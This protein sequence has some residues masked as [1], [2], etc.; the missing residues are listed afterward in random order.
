MTADAKEQQ[1]PVRFQSMGPL[2]SSAILAGWFFTWPCCPRKQVSNRSGYISVQVPML[3]ELFTW[4]DGSEQV[5]TLVLDNVRVD[6][7]DISGEDKAESTGN[8]RAVGA[9]G[10]QSTGGDE[11]ALVDMGCVHR[12]LRA[13][14][15]AVDAA[16]IGSLVNILE[17][18]KEQSVKDL[19]PKERLRRW[20]NDAMEALRQ[21]VVANTVRSVTIEQWKQS[22]LRVASDKRGMSAA[23]NVEEFVS[24]VRFS[25][26]T[27]ARRKFSTKPLPAWP[28]SLN[29]R[30][31]QVSAGGAR[32]VVIHSSVVCQLFRF[33]DQARTGKVDIVECVCFFAGKRSA[34]PSSETNA[35][36]FDRCWELL[37]MQQQLLDVKSVSRNLFSVVDPSSSGYI[38]RDQLR[39]ALKKKKVLLSER[40]LKALEAA[41]DNDEQDNHVSTSSFE[42][43]LRDAKRRCDQSRSPEKGHRLNIVREHEQQPP[44]S[45]PPFAEWE[46]AAAQRCVVEA[47]SR[48]VAH[49]AISVSREPHTKL[50][51]H[52]LEASPTGYSVRT[53]SV[54]TV[55]DTDN[56]SPVSSTSSPQPGCHIDDTVLDPGLCTVEQ[57]KNVNEHETIE[58]FSHRAKGPALWAVRAG[59]HAIDCAVSF[60][61]REHAMA[62][63]VWQ[64]VQEV[65]RRKQT[66]CGES[67]QTPADVFRVFDS[68]GSGKLSSDELSR[69]VVR[70]GLGYTSPQIHTLFDFL[71]VNGDGAIDY[72]GLVVFF[73]SMFGSITGQRQNAVGHEGYSVSLARETAAVAAIVETEQTEGSLPVHK[74]SRRRKQLQEQKAWRDKVAALDQ[75]DAQM[76]IEMQAAVAVAG[77]K[78]P[79]DL[80]RAGAGPE[81]QTVDERDDTLHVSGTNSIADSN[82]AEHEA[83]ALPQQ[84]RQQGWQHSRQ[85][86]LA[87]RKSYLRRMQERQLH[88]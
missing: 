36:L 45:K 79:P 80:T 61:S 22:F 8:S 56:E 5:E 74:A 17:G 27:Q 47:L 26:T 65:V 86:M 82:H 57:V 53:V 14:G 70:L 44:A 58:T 33:L 75:A 15:V 34:R 81:N 51:R 67:P 49:D 73:G 6:G 71:D 20:Y 16:L 54:K 7:E 10:G 35:K 28:H 1:V 21:Q 78:Q 76:E 13:V 50:C 11:E 64:R 38:S 41:L 24:A 4:L 40:D 52:D 32:A 83:P 37:S 19:D 9:A 88:Q 66:V 77:T 48:P 3:Q 2:P 46:V 43:N 31:Q 59:L 18:H 55:A 25:V 69:A 23:V 85:A 42:R 30:K 12:A 29:D 84:Q 87:K 68:D 72:R 63:A 62:R 60:Q 39:K